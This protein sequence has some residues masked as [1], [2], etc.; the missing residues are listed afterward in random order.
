MRSDEK[1]LEVEDV[2][3]MCLFARKKLQPMFEDA[4]GGGTVPR[5]K[6]EVVSHITRANML[7]WVKKEK[8]NGDW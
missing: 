4:L 7:A 8:R 1:D 2:R 3:M 6:E 5:T